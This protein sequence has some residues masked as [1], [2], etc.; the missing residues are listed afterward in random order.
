MLDPSVVQYL[1]I[2]PSLFSQ[3]QEKDVYLLGGWGP[4]PWFE[5]APRVLILRICA[6]SH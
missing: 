6:D 3:A 2:G 1:V 4:A 5:E